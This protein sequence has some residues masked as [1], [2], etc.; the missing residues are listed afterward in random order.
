MASRSDRN[1]AITAT[2]RRHP[3]DSSNRSRSVRTDG[4]PAVI[5]IRFIGSARS[6]RLS[7]NS[8][9]TLISTNLDHGA[10]GRALPR[11]DTLS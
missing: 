11:M 9:L 4:V 5:G 3:E 1:N 2:R 10:P 8:A 6:W 7:S